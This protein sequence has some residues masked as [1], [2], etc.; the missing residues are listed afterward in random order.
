MLDYQR[1]NNGMFTTYQLSQDFAGP[2]AVVGSSTCPSC[3]LSWALDLPSIST[4]SYGE[5]NIYWL[6]L[7]TPIQLKISNIY[8]YI[9]IHIHIYIYIYIMGL[10]FKQWYFQITYL[11]EDVKMSRCE[12]VKM[13]RCED[14]RMWR[15]E[16]VKMSRCEDV[17][18]W[19]WE[20]CEE[21]KMWRWEDVRMRRC[22]EE[23]MWRWEDVK[24]RRC[25]DEKMW[26]WEDV[27]MRRCEDVK[28]RRCEDEMWRWEDV[29]MRCE[30]E[31]MWRW[32]N[33]RMRRCE[34]EKMWCEDVKMVD[35]PPLLEEPFAQTP[36]GKKRPGHIYQYT[37]YTKNINPIIWI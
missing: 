13:S 16:D 1:V 12:D 20:R 3:R 7:Y 24:M 25:E 33:V 5:K 14:V 30:D 26:G 17:R 35:R 32:A 23:K 15:W 4:Q 36:S 11:W 18:M 2:S 6:M 22:E 9:Y 37:Q 8:I 28:M 21:E 31:K 34:D 29:K 27:K 10:F 19:G